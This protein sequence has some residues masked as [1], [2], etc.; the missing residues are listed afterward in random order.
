VVPRQQVPQPVRQA[1]HPLPDR[2]VGST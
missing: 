1:Q 2:H